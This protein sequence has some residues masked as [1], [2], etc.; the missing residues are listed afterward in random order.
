[1]SYSYYADLKES[2][3]AKIKE[4]LFMY[5]LKDITSGQDIAREIR[6][7]CRSIR[8]NKQRPTGKKLPEDLRG[9]SISQS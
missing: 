4:G 2:K 3:N 8:L 7:S 6:Q 9:I 5:F 1:M